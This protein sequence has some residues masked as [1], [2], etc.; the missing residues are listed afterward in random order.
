VADVL[1]AVT[2]FRPYR[3]AVGLETALAELNSQRGKQFE[4]E[5][6]DACIRVV[7]TGRVDLCCDGRKS[8]NPGGMDDQTG[9]ESDAGGD[10]FENH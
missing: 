5:V 8:E 6:V 4:A 9:E 1:D 7:S 3:P 10:I 2:C